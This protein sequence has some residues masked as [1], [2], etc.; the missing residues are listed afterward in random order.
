MSIYQGQNFSPYA[1]YTVSATT[2]SANQ[3]VTQPSTGPAASVIE[4]SNNATGVAF[5][6]WNSTAGTGATATTASYPI[7]PGQTKLVNCGMAVQN[8][9]VILDTGTTSAKV[10]VSI[11]N[12]T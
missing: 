1:N 11:G 7:L 8:V 5:V 9:A 2:T 3:V 6:A 4:V 12:G 10:Y